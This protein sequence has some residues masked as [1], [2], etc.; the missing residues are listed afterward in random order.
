MRD[1]HSVGVSLLDPDW[2][3]TIPTDRP[4]ILVEDG[5]FILLDEVQVKHVLNHITEHFSGQY[6]D[7]ETRATAPK[8][9]RL[10]RTTRLSLRLLAHW[11]AQVRHGTWVVR[12]RF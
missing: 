1:A 4:R 10:S 12:Y 7:E 6:V 5:L 8:S 2:T 9:R 11:P 3:A